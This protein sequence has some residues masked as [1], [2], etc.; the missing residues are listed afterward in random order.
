M[1]RRS[2]NVENS[3]DTTH[4]SKENL[5]KTRGFRNENEQVVQCAVDKT[6]RPVR[7]RGEINHAIR[8]DGNTAADDEIKRLSVDLKNDKTQK[9]NTTDALEKADSPN[10]K[11]SDSETLYCPRC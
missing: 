1:D 5:I 6:V 8:S 7:R 3:S 2:K 10:Q 9:T 4:K 11:H